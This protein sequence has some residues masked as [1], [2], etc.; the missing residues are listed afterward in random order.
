M[1][2]DRSDDDTP[3]PGGCRLAALVI[4]AFWIVAVAVV[5]VV[6]LR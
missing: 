5:V 3:H 2:D 6:T 1:N 4:L